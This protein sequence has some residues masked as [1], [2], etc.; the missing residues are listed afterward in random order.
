[1]FEVLLSKRSG[2]LEEE[3]KNAGFE[4]VIFIDGEK[5]VLID[6]YNKEDLR[7]EISRA[8]SK[9]KKIIVMGNGDEINRIA[10]SDKRVSMLLS[11][12]NAK[13]KDFMHYRDSGLN[14]VLCNLAL[15][16]GI[17][18]GIDYSSIK[19]MKGKER[20]ARIGRIMQNIE[21]CNKYKTPVVLASFGKKPSDPYTL[22]SFGLSLGMETSQAKKSLESAGSLL[23]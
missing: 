11:P 13:K 6:T 18:I 3:A 15:K 9:G 20:A 14:Q 21:L 23:G 22:R 16:N 12:E 2:K 4:S 10:V 19:K 1:M 17:L 8:S 7:K 5:L